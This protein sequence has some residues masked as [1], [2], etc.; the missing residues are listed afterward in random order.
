MSPCGF[1]AKPFSTLCFIERGLTSMKL[2][3]LRKGDSYSNFYIPIDSKPSKS[4][5]YEKIT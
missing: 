2:H 1:S 4:Y 3:L 5:G